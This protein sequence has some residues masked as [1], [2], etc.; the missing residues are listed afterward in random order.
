MYTILEAS[1]KVGVSK[2]TVYKKIKNSKELSK[3]VS[4]ENGIQYM[5]DAGIEILEKLISVNHA[6]CKLESNNINNDISSV[7]NMLTDLQKQ[8]NQVICKLNDQIEFLRKQL[9]EK[10]RQI[11]RNQIAINQSQI[12]LKEKEERVLELES[13]PKSWLSNLFK[14]S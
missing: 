4:T 10:D 12:L 14:G 3:C 9:E 8:D 1:K 13:K 6:Q 11:E 7:V 5:S 2:V